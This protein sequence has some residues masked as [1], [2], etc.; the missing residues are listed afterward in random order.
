MR[1]RTQLK[2]IAHDW[3]V[4][5]QTKERREL[6]S[7]GEVRSR[8]CFGQTESGESEG[9]ARSVS[10]PEQCRAGQSKGAVG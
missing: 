1:A 3:R 8:E 10:S 2:N 9:A 4:C 5:L 6:W 7:S